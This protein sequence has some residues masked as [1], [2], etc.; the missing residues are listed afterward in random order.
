M[1][2]ETCC[3]ALVNCPAAAEVW[4]HKFQDGFRKVTKAGNF[5]D[6]IQYIGN[7][8]DDDDLGFCLVLFWFIWFERNQ[9]VCGERLE[10]L[11]V[12]VTGLWIFGMKLDQLAVLLIMAKMLLRTGYLQFCD[13]AFSKN[14]RIGLGVVVRNR[15][16]EVMIFSAKGGFGLDNVALAEALAIWERILVAQISSLWPC[17]IES[18]C[19]N[20][21]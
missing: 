10:L 2:I 3:H 1:V 7:F 4:K 16:G 5:Y 21:C 14:G 6:F 18:D 8:F 9:R 20:V 19:V 13:A 17:K 11:V 15:K 12:F